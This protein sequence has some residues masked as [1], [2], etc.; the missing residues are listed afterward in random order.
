LIPDRAGSETVLLIE[1]DELVRDLVFSI[2][3]QQGYKVLVAENG[4]K[5]LAALNSR[6]VPIDLV[7]TDVNMPDM[8]GTQLVEQISASHP[9]ARV[10]YMSADGHKIIDRQEFMESGG[11]YLQKPFSIRRLAAKVLEVLG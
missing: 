5:A 2:L 9:D 6:G 1:D 11:S 8:D 4:Q 3:H 10:L 7:L